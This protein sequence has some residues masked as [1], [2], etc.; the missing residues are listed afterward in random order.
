MSLYYLAANKT[1]QAFHQYLDRKFQYR[2]ECEQ[3]LPLIQQI[4]KEY[5]TLSAREMYRIIQ[6]VKL[7]RDKFE[8][9]CFEEGFKVQKKPAY[10]RT[11]N[12]LGV[13]RFP[14]LITG[15]ELKGINHLWVSDITYYRIK[16]RFYYLTFILDRFSRRLIGHSVSK[17][18][19]T[20]NT[21]IPALQMAFK[22]R[23]GIKPEIFHS[24]GGGQYYCKE[25]LKITGNEIKN[26]MGECAYENPHAERINGLIK[27]D[28][29]DFYSPKSF[30]EL[31]IQT[32]RAVN[33]YNLKRHS[34]TG[35]SPMLL[36][37]LLTNQQILTKE[38]KKQK[39]KSQQQLNN[40]VLT[41]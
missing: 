18:L 31:I 22:N 4:R 12:S 40:F 19:F 16:D 28:Y 25:F 10:H 34:A 41:S 39:K 5:P 3:L 21:T 7:G 24:D 29:L 37:E 20:E 6:P 9:F 1:K 17:N 26:S 27:N 23:N 14:N 32:N 30:D 2:N 15:L 36:E 13:T 8:S 11:T 38:K 35:L 33:N